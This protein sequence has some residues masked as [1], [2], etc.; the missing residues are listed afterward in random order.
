MAV[1]SIINKNEIEGSSRIDAEYYQPNILDAA[2]AVLK[3][4]HSTLGSLVKN[5]YRVVYENTKILTEEE[6]NHDK[7][8]LFMQAAN[9]SSDGLSFDVENMGYVHEAD[10]IRYPKGRVNEG[11]ILIEVKGQAEKVAIVPSYVPERTLVSGTLYK[12]CL[13]KGLSHEY[14]F[15]YMSSRYG[16]LLRDRLKTNTLIAYV[17]K[18][19]LYSIPVYLPGK[20]TEQEIKELIKESYKV[21]Q[22][23]KSM[24]S[25]AEE[26][27]LVE[28]G[29]RKLDI[30]DDLFYTA[31]LNEVKDCNRIDAEYYIPK[32]K[33]L[34]HHIAKF[35]PQQLDDLGRFKKGIEPGSEKYEDQGAP[36]IRVSNISKMELNDNNQ[37]Y[38]A[39]EYYNELR[40]NYEPKIDEMLLTKDA[41][42][43]IAYIL[44]EKVEGIISGGIIRVKLN[45]G[46]K[47]EYVALVINSLIGQ[48]QIKRDAGGAI[49]NHWRPDQIRAMVIPMLSQP[50]QEKIEEICLESFNKRKEGKR[51]LEQAKSKIEAMIDR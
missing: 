47:K 29:L 5:G 34:M 3:S 2:N 19:D 46:V 28:I 8:C 45:P 1:W 41:T 51:L 16:K 26:I 31:S 11:E 48:M 40:R 6:V 4:S 23:A 35:S 37:K 24:Y 20:E 15:A 27:V 42:P 49:I 22:E 39:K 50:I 18:P 10:W 36:F 38:L 25:K 17:S 13:K 12:L 32:Y 14:L 7:D 43:G 30:K 21:V 44:K 33:I 9:I